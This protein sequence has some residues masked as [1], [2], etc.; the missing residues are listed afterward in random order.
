[1]YAVG[2]GLDLVTEK[3]NVGIKAAGQQGRHDSSLGLLALTPHSTSFIMRHLILNFLILF[4]AFR[5]VFSVSLSRYPFT[6]LALSTIFNNQAA[7][8]DGSADFDGKGNSFVSDL[9]PSG[10][11][12][13]DGIAYDLPSVWGN[14]NDNV[15][16]NGQVF[17]L[18]EPTYV[19]ELHFVYSGD[20]GDGTHETVQNFQLNFEDNSTQ[21]VQLYA[22][23]WWRWPILNFGNIRTPYHF[24]SNRTSTNWNSS[25]I[26]QWSSAVS[27]EQKLQSIAFPALNSRR[28]HLFAMAISPSLLNSSSSGASGPQLSI[29]RA[30]FTS[31]WEN[32]G[33]VRAQAVEVTIANMLPNAAFSEENSLNSRHSVEI[34]G[35]GITM[36]SPGV[37]NRLVPGDQVKVDVLVSGSMDGTNATIVIKDAFGNVI[38]TSPDWPVTSLIEKWTPDAAILSTHE[39]PTWWNKAKY[40]ILYGFPQRY[41]GV[42]QALIRDL[43]DLCL[44]S[45]H[46][47]VYSVPAWAPPKQYAEWYDWY[48]RTPPN[49]S[50]PSWE[51]HLETFGPNVTYDDFIANF[52]ASKFNASDWVN[53]FDQAGAKYFVLVTKHHDGFSLF[54]TGNTTNRSSVALGPKRDFVVELLETSAREKPHIHRGT[55][56]SLPEWFNPDYAQYGFGQWPG[57]L[58]HNAFNTSLIDTYTGHVSVSDYIEDVQFPHMLDL[59]TKY[60]TDIMWC[61]IGGPNKTLEFAA[62][63][64]NHALVTGRQVTI[65][66]RCGAVPDFDTPEYATFGAIQTRS[67]E[68]SEGMDPFSYGL[69]SATTASQYKNATTIIQTL[70]DIVS[71]NG[72]FLIDIGPTAEGEIIAPMANN[73]LEAGTWLQ[74]SGECVYDTNYWFQSSQ[75]IVINKEIPARFTSTPDTFCIVAFSPP[76]QD[77]QTELIINKRLP[78]LTGDQIFFLSPSSD[79]LQVPWE[80]DT[81][82]GRTKI[83]L[84][85]PRIME[86]I[87]QVNFAWAFKAVYNRK[88]Q[89]VT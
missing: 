3:Q 26:F 64:Y 78:L 8:S 36:L 24:I 42:C 12:M 81:V 17:N 70:V 68:S 74:H 77:G 52:T 14:G 1:M 66:N 57:G 10:P 46:W 54:D 30:R 9:L 23:N 80:M 18:E 89:T 43:W 61:D 31:R 58:P 13:N 19:H 56:Y 32:V 15:I 50:N 55:Y 7:S 4:F 86:E 53:L 20:A 34:T 37:V 73:L 2:P 41:S 79:S 60:N 84:S 71:K 22:R 40:G 28:L 21:L 72:N 11:W 59:A 16:A 45:I 88:N 27:S 48:M 47:G 76:G 44:F 25:Q 65:N 69:N 83:D 49:S 35:P 6:N 67:W 33:D 75:D 29:R 5:A 85:N 82:T 39:T 62:A 63:F 51:H 38:G 87:S